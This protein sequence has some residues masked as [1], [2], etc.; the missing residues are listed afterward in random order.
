[1]LYNTFK[2]INSD[3]KIYSQV[4]RGSERSRKLKQVGNYFEDDSLCENTRILLELIFKCISFGI[5]PKELQEKIRS[6][7]KLRNLHKHRKAFT[8]SD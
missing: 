3:L 1:M 4:D 5:D 7:V 2:F 8:D 6:H